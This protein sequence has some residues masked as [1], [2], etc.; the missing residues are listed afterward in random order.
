V[1]GPGRAHEAEYLVGEG[2]EK[3]ATSLVIEQPAK[4]GPPASL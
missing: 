1:H 3:F 2:E 4:T